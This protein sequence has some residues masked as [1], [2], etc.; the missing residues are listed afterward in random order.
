MSAHCAL[1][2][3]LTGGWTRRSAPTTNH[4]DCSRNWAKAKLRHKEPNGSSAERV[5][6]G[7]EERRNVRIGT[8]AD[9]R[10]YSNGRKYAINESVTT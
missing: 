5:L 4:Q 1:L 10:S 9:A 2:K 3:M 7:K 8:C 6:F